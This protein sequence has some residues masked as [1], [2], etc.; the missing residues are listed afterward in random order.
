MPT[1]KIDLRRPLAV[2][3]LVATLA[4]VP[5]AGTMSVHAEPDRPQF[6]DLIEANSPAVVNIRTTMTRKGGDAGRHPMPETMPGA[7]FDDFFR[8]FFEQMP[9]QGPHGRP[10]HGPALGQGSGF[11]V[12]A[13]GHVVTNN[14]VI[15]NADEI[16]VVTDDGTTYI[17]ELVGTDAKTDLAVLKIEAD[18]ALP[19]VRFGD[20]DEAR[21][22]DW[23]IAIGNPFGLGGTATAGIISARG[24]DLQAGP[25]DDFIQ[26]DAPINRGNSGGPVFNT[27]GEVIGVNTM[28]YSP[29]GGNVGIGF[30]I[31]SALVTDIVAD[32]RAN[33]SVKRGWLG[34]QIQGVSPEIADSL[35]LGDDRGALIAQVETGSP[36]DEAGLESGDVIVDFDGKDIE[37]VKDLTRVVASTKADEKVEVGVWR[38]GKRRER[39]VRI[40]AQPEEPLQLASADDSQRGKLGLELSPLTPDMRRQ[41]R[42]PGKVAGALVV[43]VDPRGPAARQ[44]VRPGDVISMVG[45]TTVDSPDQVREQVEAAADHD[46]DHVLLRIERNGGS[47]FL[48]MKLT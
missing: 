1:R 30:A 2:L 32:L 45:Q 38:D 5:F 47:R 13:D 42:V 6:A 24:R 43:G 48:A 4:I 3:A 18:D 29:N 44:G 11:I 25:Y 12:S 37:T 19:F 23:I 27:D 41:F 34:V 33:G 10:P 35:G 8:R 46:R 26:I 31:P 28:I 36:A 9:Q 16:S 14:H 39:D 22:G 40:G 17:A 15:E 20:S 21:T 7:P